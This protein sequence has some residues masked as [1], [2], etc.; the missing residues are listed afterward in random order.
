M[1]IRGFEI[2]IIQVRRLGRERFLCLGLVA[3]ELK[4]PT[5]L[6]EIVYL[7][8]EQVLLRSLDLL[9]LVVRIT[10]VQVT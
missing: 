6:K 10:L 1:P 8:A 9:V 2:W 5:L 3:H 4:L 7:C